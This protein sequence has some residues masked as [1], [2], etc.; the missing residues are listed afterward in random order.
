M[1]LEKAFY[2]ECLVLRVIFVQENGNR[3]N[4][5]NMKNAQRRPR[6]PL[7]TIRVIYAAVCSMDKLLYIDKGGVRLT[8][9]LRRVFAEPSFRKSSAN[10][11]F[12]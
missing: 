5:L 1:R 10:R 7:P 9:I 6:N 4:F 3:Q 12:L 11:P 8:F 2:F